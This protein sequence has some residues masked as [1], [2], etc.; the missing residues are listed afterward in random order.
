MKIATPLKKVTHP[1]L[2]TPLEVEVLSSPPYIIGFHKSPEILTF[3]CKK[4]ITKKW[5]TLKQ[6]T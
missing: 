2:A 1:V 5:T 3:F 6:F 4:I